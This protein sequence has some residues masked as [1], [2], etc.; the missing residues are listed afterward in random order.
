MISFEEVRQQNL[1]EWPTPVEKTVK[2]WA[3]KNGNATLH[4]TK[5]DALLV[6]N[7]LER[8]VSNDDEYK[9]YCL[10]RTTTHNQIEQLWKEEVKE[11]YPRLVELDIFD[12]VFNEA[13][14]NSGDESFGEDYYTAVQYHLEKLDLFLM[15][16]IDKLLK[17]D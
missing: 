5:T 8:T 15:P 16:I 4:N 7:K 2:W 6:S 10:A 9:E 17:V 3:Y 13:D 12:L 1:I 11:E 14:T